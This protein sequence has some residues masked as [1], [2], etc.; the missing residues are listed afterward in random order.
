[1]ADCAL[2]DDYYNFLRNI[3]NTDRKQIN[4]GIDQIY[5][6]KSYL[7]YTERYEQLSLTEKNKILQ[8][9]IEK[10]NEKPFELLEYPKAT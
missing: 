4:G 3:L 10:Y 5:I 7:D 2:H 1:M 8:L 9:Y 6:K